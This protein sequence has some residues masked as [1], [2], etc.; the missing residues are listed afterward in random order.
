MEL[1]ND[2][3][4]LTQR[5]CDIIVLISQGHSAKGIA[6]IMQ[7]SPRTVEGLIENCRFKLQARNTSQLVSRAITGGH[8]PLQE[9]T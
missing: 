6:R 7:L 9:K 3:R 5:E 1:I 4:V 8:L 2:Y